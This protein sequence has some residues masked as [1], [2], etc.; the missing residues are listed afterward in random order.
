MSEVKLSLIVATIGRNKELNLLLNSLV[1]QTVDKSL[2]EVIIVDQNN[3]DL[4]IPTLA[5]YN[6]LLNITHV[7]SNQI[8]LSVNRNLGIQHSKGDYLCVPDD[9][10]TYYPD[11]L[12][13]VFRQLSFNHHPD[14]IIGKV[15]DR[16]RKVYVFKK[17]PKYSTKVNHYNFYNLV[18]SISIFFKKNEICFDEN[19]G[20]GAEYPSNEDG[21]LI[22]SFL[23]NNKSVLYS[24]TIECNHPPYSS[25][26][27]SN[28]KLYAYGIGFGALCK[29]FLSISILILFFKVVV[30]QSLMLL[31]YTI[32]LDRKNMMRRWQSLKGR[33]VGILKY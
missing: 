7:K 11:T 8:G 6:S 17:T 18:S 32:V 27:M 28:Q 1:E 12:E 9:D 13:E 14:M 19:F 24:P 23:K 20:I 25:A 22:L 5:T 3:S 10:C 29:K 30:F 16:E 4:I 26:N 15:Y 2:F 31:R 33:C 21:V